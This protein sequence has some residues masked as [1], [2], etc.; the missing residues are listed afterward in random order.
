MYEQIFDPVGNSLGLSTLFAVLPLLTIFVL[1][2]VVR[3]KAQ[4][5]GLIALAVALVVA[6]AV[7][8]MPVGQALSSA[9]EGAA[10]GIFPIMWIVV[11]AIWIYNMTVTTG[12]FDVLRRSFGTVSS[13]QRI[14]AIIIAFCFGGLMEAL[15][16][17]GTPVAISAVMLIALGFSPMKAA[18]VALVANTAPVAFGAIAVPITTLA[19]ITGLPVHELASTVGR[20]TPILALF[21][22]LVL[23]LLVDGRRGIRQ[24]WLPA[25][26]AGMVFAVLQFVSSNYL[27]VELTDI[28]ASLGAAGALVILVRFWQPAEELAVERLSEGDMKDRITTASASAHA[29]ETG[30]SDGNRT[31]V[32][33]GS[34]GATGDAGAD[35]EPPQDS[36]STVLKAYS[37]YLIII[38][39][40]SIAQI[41]AVK[42]LLGAGT[43]KFAWPGLDIVTPDGKPPSSVTF[44]FGWLSAAGTL[45]LISGLITMAVLG[46]KPGAAVRAFGATLNQLKWAILTVAAVLALAYVMNF[47]GQT[48]TIGQWIAGTGSF[49]A[50]LSPV[51]GWLGVAVTG[52]D[53]SSNALFGTLQVAAAQKAGLSEVLLAAANSSGG[54]LGKMISPQNLAIAAAATAMPGKEGDL[55][56]KVI[57]WSLAFLL[58]M[59]VLVYLQS[60]PVLSWM[61]P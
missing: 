45:L 51:L 14:Q 50:F 29:V 54:V 24:C 40:F 27:S 57:G 25:V 18:T 47:S 56:R 35:D 42:T 31:S 23:V 12:H 16:G 58:V 11:T 10:F 39:V 38:A 15:A 30:R 48:I 20:Q 34:A 32:T 44:A 26:I 49:F 5:A 13:D 55:F 53:T 41:S 4:W 33:T 52:S 7:Y 21:V 46:L 1:L 61:L 60:T 6:V 3:M 22:P 2:G 19:K 8:G 28:I 59:C 36:R 43:V 37:P 9:G 17:F